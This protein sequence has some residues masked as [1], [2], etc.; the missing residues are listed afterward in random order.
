MQTRTT[1]KQNGAVALERGVDVLLAEGSGLASRGHE[2]VVS[3]DA[4]HVVHDTETEVSGDPF[5]RL[6]EF[7]NGFPE[8][9]SLGH[10]ALSTVVEVLASKLSSHDGLVVGVVP[11]V[12]VVDHS[13]GGDIVVVNTVVIRV[14]SSIAGF[15]PV[16]NPNLAVRV[17]AGGGR[18]EL[19][20]LVLEGL[21]VLL[22]ER[23]SFAGGHV[24]LAGFIGLID[25]HSN[26]GITFD[27]ELLEVCHLVATP[28][29]RHGGQ[30]KRLAV[31]GERWAPCVKE[32]G[33][34]GNKVREIR[35][36]A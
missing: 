11:K 9:V 1:R 16:V 28:Q 27:N 34:A 35:R 10:G 13:L 14:A 20:T 22:P 12:Q 29:H 6:H 7:D 24:G 8:G 33:V 36:L 4:L 5:G 18:N 2:L 25:A 19:V 26:V 32:V 23:C 21:E 17:R 3:I 30:A 31:G 15:V